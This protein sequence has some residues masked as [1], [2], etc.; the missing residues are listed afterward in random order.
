MV[1]MVSAQTWRY[2]SELHGDMRNE[3]SSLSLR[4]V[5]WRQR[6]L[7]DLLYHI[8]K[9]VGPKHMF[10][11]TREHT[12]HVH[13]SCNCIVSVV[14]FEAYCVRSAL[15]ATEV[16]ILECRVLSILQCNMYP[17]RAIVYT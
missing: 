17:A 5:A 15:Y 11:K 1:V 4:N 13:Y 16:Q 12:H 3:D 7:L 2:T 10:K 8:L 6:L 14:E 9:S